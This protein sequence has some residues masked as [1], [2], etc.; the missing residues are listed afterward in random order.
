MD[1]D[2]PSKIFLTYGSIISFMM[3]KPQINET[4]IFPDPQDS[5]Y[6]DNDADDKKAKVS[7]IF[8]TSEFLYSQGVFNEYCFFYNFK[9]KNDIKYNYYNSLFLVLPKGDYD[10]LTKLRSLKRQLK[11]EYFLEDEKD[12]D[13]QQIIDTYIKFKQEIYTNQQYSIKL[14]TSKDNYVNFNDCVQF[15]HIK[16]GKFLEFKKNP[17]T[18]RIYIRLTETL[19]ENTIFRFIPAYP[20][21]GENSAKV[22]INLILKIACGENMLS[23]DNEKFINKKEKIN[24]NTSIIRNTLDKNKSNKKD[25]INQKIFEFGKNLILNAMKKVEEVRNK[26]FVR[27]KNARASLQILVN[28]NKTQEIIRRNFITFINMSNIPYK[29]FGKKIIPDDNQ[30][31]TAGNGE[32]NF[33]R[34]IQ[35]SG[36]FIEDNKYINSLD[37][38]CIQNNERNLFI[39]AIDFNKKIKEGKNNN[40]L[41]NMTQIENGEDSLDSIINNNNIN[42]NNI[43]N[44][45]NNLNNISNILR[46]YSRT[47]I[48]NSGNTIKLNYFYDQDF[49]GDINY[50]IEVGQFGENDYIEPLGIFKFE[51]LYNSGK[52]GEYE[53]DSKN[54]IDICKDQCY[55]RIINVFTNKVLMADM[56]RTEIGNIYKLKLVNNNNLDKKEYYQTIF[57]IEKVKDIE[58]LLINDNKNKEKIKINTGNNDA[59]KKNK[60][61]KKYGKQ[62]IN[63]NDY[64][65]IKSKKYNLYL[66]IKLSNNQNKRLMLTNSMSDLTKFKLN[67]L[68]EIDKYELH[69]FEQLL[70][71]FNNIINFFKSE[72][73]S[74][75][76]NSINIESYSNYLKIQHIL[77]NLE[78]KINNFPE[79][80]KVNISQKNKFDFMKVI[81]HFKIVSK[82][83]DIFLTNWFHEEK[84]L[85]YFE[86][87]NRLEN[88]FKY[89]KEEELTLLKCKK[90]ISNK[91]FKILKNIYDLNKSYLNV[92]K[93]RLLYF[94]M[95]IGRDEKCTKFL[96]Y[97]LRD[98]GTLLIS[99][100]PLNSSQIN[101]Q[102]NEFSTNSLKSINNN[103][104]I[105]T[106]INTNDINNLNNINNFESPNKF[107]YIKYC[108]K[109]IMKTYNSIDFVKYKINF[110]SVNLLFNI[111]SCFILYNQKPFLQFYDEYFKDME[112]LK[113]KDNETFP[114]YEQNSI[115]VHFVLKNNKIFIKKKKFLKNI[116]NDEEEVYTNLKNYSIKNDE[117]EFD[118]DELINIS[119][120]N[121]SVN[122]YAEI[123][124][125]RL[126][127]M[128]LLFYSNL[129][130]CNQDFKK[131]LKKV[132][133]F[134]NLIDNYLND[135][136]NYF[137][138]DN[139]IQSFHKLGNK[140]K[141]E[142]EV[143]NDL[144]CYLI[145]L[146]IYLYFRIS[147]PFQGKMNL[148]YCLESGDSIN[149][150]INNLN[151]S[152]IRSEKPKKIDEKILDKIYDY[153]CQLLK[154]ISASN[155][156]IQNNPFFFLVILESAKY[157]IRNLYIYKK[158][159][160]KIDKSIN[161]MSLI[162]LLFEKYF[163][164]YSTKEIIGKNKTLDD[165]FNTI[166]NDDLEIT[167]NLYLISDNSKLT[168]EK[169]RKKLEK[170]IKSKGNLTNKAKFKKILLILSSHNDIR[171]DQ[172]NIRE[173]EQRKKSLDNLEQY[174]IST[175][176][177][178]LSLK[179][180]VY[181]D[182]IIDNILLMISQT[183]LEFL[184]Y[185]ENLEIE[186]VFVNINKL[187][188]KRP[189]IHENQ[190]EDDYYDKLLNL[191]TKYNEGYEES[192]SYSDMLINQY[193][194]NK[195]DNNLTFDEGN[196][197]S[198]FK[199]IQLD[200]NVEFRKKILEIL[201][202]RNSQRKIF[203]DNIANIVLFE[204]Q[205]QYDKFIILRD[206]FIK[207]FNTVQSFTLI[208]RLDNISFSLLK[209]LEYEFNKL[210]NHLLDERKWRNENK[211]FN[212]NR[213]SLSYEEKKIEEKEKKPGMKRKLNVFSENLPEND[214]NNNR[215]FI[216]VF[217]QENV[218]TGQQ[219]LYNLGFV[220]LI[221][222]I[223]EY[224]S[225]VVNIR[226]ELRDEL[227]LLEQILIAIY[228]LLVVFSFQNQKHQIIIREK[229]YIY[230]YP[231]KLNI[232]SRDILLFIG[233]FL[234][235]IFS[236]KT[237][238]DFNQIQ[239]LDEVIGSL[240]FLENLD[241][242]KN[243]I[244]IPFYV[245]TFKVIISFCS[246]KY[247]SQ[248]L[249]VLVIINDVLVNE[250][251]QNTY[252][253]EDITSL[254]KILE[255]I[256]EEQEKKSNDIKNA[257]ILRLDS[258]I[259]AFLDLI[260]LVNENNL[261]KYLKLF[262]IFVIVTN[263]FYNHFLLYKN[264][265]IINKNYQ[266]SLVKTLT[267]FCNNFNLT[268]EMIFCNDNNINNLKYLNEF[269]GISLPK[270][271]II[272]SSFGSRKTDSDEFLSQIIGLTN[273]LYE[274]I[275]IKRA[276]NNKEKSFLMKKN[277]EELDEIISKIGS[278]IIYLTLVRKKIKGNLKLNVKKLINLI[279]FRKY[280]KHKEPKIDEAVKGSFCGI[281]NKIRMK[282]NMNDGLNYFQTYAK[283][284]INKER[285]NYIELI[286]NFFEKMINTAKRR[287][288][289]EI[290]EVND[291]IIAYFDSYIDSIKD[292][293]AKDFINYKNEIYFFYW[294][295]IH[296]MRYNTD[297]NKFMI[298]SNNI[299][300]LNKMDK[301]EIDNIITNK[302]KE[303]DNKTTN[304]FDY[305]L[306]PYNKKFF[307]N[308]NFIELTIK[309]FSSLNIN[310]PDY[311]YILYIKFLNSYLD[312]L[313]PNE[314][315][316]FFR[317]FIEQEQTENIFA[318]IKMVLDSLDKEINITLSQSYEK[319]EQK[320]YAMNLLENDIDKYELI[321]QFISKLSADNSPMQHVM[322]NY[323]RS[324]Y[325][326]TKSF[327][328][329]I[330]LSNIL[331]NFTKESSN[332]VYISK[333][334]SIIIQILD[335]LSKC[336]NGPCIENQN[337]IVIET[338][339]LYFVKNILKKIT[340]RKRVF[341]DDSGLHLN[342]CFD[343]NVVD[344]G[345]ENADEK[346]YE[347]S[348]LISDEC[349]NLGLTRQKL[350]YLKYKLI[351]FVAIL[352]LGRK[353]G[354]NIY[355][356][357]HK[358]ID[359]DVLAS[360]LIETYKEIL[361][362]RESQNHY[363]NLYFDEDM[364]QRMEKDIKDIIHNNIDVNENFIIFEIGTFTFIL[365]NRYLENLTK[366]MDNDIMEKIKV[367]NKN[368]KEKKYDVKIKSIFDSVTSFGSSI[369]R[370][371]K[372]LCIK[373]GNCLT[374]NK[375]ED[376]QL[377]QS[378]SLAYGFYYDYTPN[379][380]LMVQGNIM[381]YFV[382]LSPICKCLTD[383]MKEEFHSKVDRSS[384]KS[385]IRSLF[386]N[387]DY[388]HYILVYTKKRLD[389]FRKLAIIDL[390]LNHY[391]FY[392]DVFMTI[393]LLQ[394]LLIFFSLYRT[395][396]DYME[397]TEY[398][399][400]FT[401]DYGFLYKEENITITRNI[402]F[403]TTII[404]CIL[405]C[406]ILLTYILNRFP[407]WLYFEI[408]ENEQMRYYNKNYFEEDM[409]KNSEIF[410]LTD[411]E[412]K[413]ENVKLYQKIS[414]FISN[415]IKDGMLLYH[416]LVLVDCLIALITQNYRFLSFLLGEIICHSDTLKCIVKSFW[417]PRKH[418]IITFVLFY[419]IA[420]YFIIFVYL[421]I[422]HQLPTKDC[423]I[424]S[425]CFF[426]LCDQTIKNSNG[427]I[428]YLVEDGLYITDTLYSN[429]RFWIDNWFALIDIMLVLPMACSIIINSYIAQKN[430]NAEYEKDKNNTCF[431]CGLN[432]QEL[433]KYYM[434]E[435]GFY[436]HIKLDHY[437][438]NYMFNLF[439]ILKK[440]P[441]NLMSM[442]KSIM[443]NYKIGMYYAWVPYKT[444]CKKK[445]IESKNNF[446]ENQ[447]DSEGEID[448]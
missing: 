53:P 444:C 264:E 259:N 249:P 409:N 58:D 318:F 301:N 336:C 367:I 13:H 351:Y 8:T 7:D 377:P 74:F 226:N 134:D 195:K 174:D 25:S 205:N 6:K 69:F 432:K 257:P 448:D 181:E 144:K 165:K 170:I 224:V 10:S 282:I 51:F 376:F 296:L 37:Y 114:N 303:I 91:I 339:L 435:K 387:L 122:N 428:N 374:T 17:E 222:K 251:R 28:D 368:L 299:L 246:Y 366:P 417:L 422:P 391:K 326:N 66:G 88:Y 386:K 26:A 194:I 186:K 238:E 332:R 383:E 106:N 316:N 97:I 342:P 272:L 312:G 131:Y 234:I 414:S 192:P 373:C 268:D 45:T 265:Y 305:S 107:T 157:V 150:N 221:N 147:F 288:E 300:D 384:K 198:F 160:Q 87:E 248:I 320:K 294:T 292:S 284:E 247:F 11:N 128:N 156:V 103:N 126:V 90:I 158:D 93:D 132:F 241:W 183:F 213:H 321:I 18:L 313:P 14:L 143:I 381:K 287:S 133:H 47:S 401:Y 311:S 61:K 338:N 199:F 2:K 229:L 130:L 408:S 314:I 295:N 393:G 438:W 52:Y 319:Q 404:Q 102:Y 140:K 431:I 280:L 167:E 138:P 365:I 148:F 116:N 1:I 285:M 219:T 250:I 359:F 255:L 418:L 216:S 330:I 411:Y 306:T 196:N 136:N 423:F 258:I 395:N 297:K 176:L 212:E 99:L 161:L 178:E 177:L 389:L 151:S 447:K 41:E 60:T 340:Y 261:R 98:N 218:F 363:E 3:N 206:I 184:K 83:I 379:I 356:Q 203:Y 27:A 79:N 185:I 57:I 193:L 361:I 175:I 355:A 159:Q 430:E 437:L 325:N 380:E 225:W 166:I 145:K 329:I 390:L 164:F 293:Y 283:Y 50:N 154:K 412:K 77:I 445:E 274:K 67:C 239:H 421:F 82:L 396:D 270:L 347:D 55:V 291:S 315:E 271:Y 333:Y 392:R 343:R 233:Y 273:E 277:E 33:W 286:I 202:R 237:Y 180:N 127:G 232:K 426:T 405:A 119:N 22:M 162:L 146:L 29:G 163:G 20:Y 424:F 298:S 427:I 153:I 276:R 279:N 42:I 388:Y 252:T 402:F 46:L 124:L 323:L 245:E 9:N 254:I 172:Y 235:N 227:V 113:T 109:R 223:F 372:A 201:Y 324:Q 397:V 48:K 290:K 211:L 4:P 75:S 121:D 394:N 129:S 71:S 40:I 327:N 117:F 382:K 123:I 95:F 141:D 179:G 425:D 275:L 89:Y 54:K 49:G 354:D 68:D 142:F 304:F 357:I 345:S 353:K 420:Y 415:L 214:M 209:E 362:E 43:N 413:R 446:E 24:K 76:G 242:G 190:S 240:N 263:L 36:N 85:D 346:F 210:I 416:V 429:P 253:K 341:N 100:C 39:Q 30:S 19:S 173:S 236:F 182:N 228:K 135:K 34:L 104:N 278:E 407:K 5:L 207:L 335:C 81:E 12:I 350:S 441:N 16:S 204:T 73:D 256:T 403:V 440:N 419:L 375:R 152:I 149:N 105:N 112:I 59:S 358:I 439:N 371:F 349:I 118:L 308:L 442:D 111:L 21:Q 399:D 230:L 64:I 260:N 398:S 307:R 406:F 65:K 189:E 322:K 188:K 125:T 443:D 364:L 70:W 436:E 31:I 137:S 410:C 62:C 72:K 334:Y 197:I 92:I 84:N 378:F 302:K 191:I 15:L 281:W 269:I 434:H 317:F 348:E 217:S 289:N 220:D 328:F 120:E 110:S 337:C 344:L 32:N 352:P 243:K 155:E 244:I 139:L 86:M 80:N 231:L 171:Q 309:Q 370:C 385:K 187:S 200:D 215:Y 262:Q 169:Y 115:L 208:K 310:S 101:N 96:I 331:V 23:G 266:I 360:L 35:F 168:F 108:L 63:K 267:H 78:K 56:K 369:Y 38:F 400:D 433:N 44:E 94:L